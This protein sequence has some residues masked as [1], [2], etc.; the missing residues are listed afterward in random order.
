[1]CRKAGFQVL[2]K[3]KI[4]FLAGKRSAPPAFSFHNSRLHFASHRSAAVLF[5]LVFQTLVQ[6]RCRRSYHSSDE[7]SRRL[8]E[9]QRG[10]ANVNQEIARPRRLQPI[11]RIQ[12]RRHALFARSRPSDISRF[13][14]RAVP[15]KFTESHGCVPTCFHRLLI[16]V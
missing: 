8:V 3:R 7:R 9:L 14:Y 6:L 10:T 4:S 2:E 12:T 16:S 5:L 11:R 15:V 1:M 13:D